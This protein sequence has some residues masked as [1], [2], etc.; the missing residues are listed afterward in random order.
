MFDTSAPPQG[1][2]AASTHLSQP[3]PP[4]L[5]HYTS[6][7]AMQG[8]VTSKTIW[9]SE[10]RFLNDQEEFLHAKKLTESLIDEQPAS[11]P[12]GF[13][14]QKQLRMAVKAAFNS[15][16]MHDQRLRIMVASFSAAGDQLS[17]WRGYA[18][19]S[20]GV[21]LGLDLRHLRTPAGITSTETFAPCL[22]KDNEKRSLLKAILTQCS[23]GL[24]EFWA[25]KLKSGSR[26]GDY[27]IA[28]EQQIWQPLRPGGNELNES[29]FRTH[30]ELQFDLLRVGPLLKNESFSEEKE[31]R[32]VLPIEPI[33]LPTNRTIQFRAT[34][35]SLIPYVA[36]PLLLP[37]QESP[38]N[39][40]RAFVGPGSH[41]SAV[42]GVNM[43]LAQNGI[44][45]PAMTSQIPY[46]P[47]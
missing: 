2:E 19:E 7:A 28:D 46:R 13:P 10:Y 34:A 1:C 45:T 27:G 32:L 23:M 14:L 42:L 12:S 29:L 24:E 40:T 18:G 39:C 5:W 21:S 16:Q 6:F 44:P 11:T 43:F 3:I 17:Q 41:P 47:K 38:I 4:V 26:I 9:A 22:Y 31:W 15:E 25:R 33:F 35:S 8:I 37:R 36:Y 30:R 20:T